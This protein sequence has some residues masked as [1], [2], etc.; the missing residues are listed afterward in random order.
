MRKTIRRSLAV[1]FVSVMLV[2]SMAFSSFAEVNVSTTSASVCALIN[3]ER[4]KN[5]LKLLKWNDRLAQ[6]ASVRSDEAMVNWSHTRPNGSDWWT[7]DPECMY[8]E[9]LA[10]NYNSAEAVVNAWME[11]PSHKEVIL[12]D[13]LSDMGISMKEGTEGWYYTVEFM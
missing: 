11:S 12:R 3:E 2:F 8:G 9:V 6:D 1:C 10:K 13:D 7:L 4:A 5:G